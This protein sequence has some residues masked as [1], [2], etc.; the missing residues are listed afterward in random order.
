[1]YEHAVGSLADFRQELEQILS[2]S[3]EFSIGR[4][5]GGAGT[6]YPALEVILIFATSATTAI[7]TS[8]LSEL[9]KDV[10]KA[11]KGKL[12]KKPFDKDGTMDFS[13]TIVSP[14]VVTKGTIRTDNFDNVIEVMKNAKEM[15]DNASKINVSEVEQ[16]ST[17]KIWWRDKQIIE[18][19]NFF[20]QYEYDASEAKW[21]LKKIAKI[22]KGI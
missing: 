6:P 3:F 16:L 20:F 8:V 9:G 15:F 4:E 17:M 18:R 19:G 22:E 21:V 7:I 1:L 12:F 2:T 14:E 13:I 11:L 10:Y 5:T